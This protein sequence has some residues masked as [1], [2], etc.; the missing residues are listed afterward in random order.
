MSDKRQRLTP[1]WLSSED[2][3]DLFS[4]SKPTVTRWLNKW[5]AAIP[6]RMRLKIGRSGLL[7]RWRYSEEVVKVLEEKLRNDNSD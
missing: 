3:A 5:D 4:V 2:L 1:V 6:D 7:D